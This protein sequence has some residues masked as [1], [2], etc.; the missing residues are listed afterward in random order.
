MDIK[1]FKKYT[2]NLDEY[3]AYD[4]D[5]FE[6]MTDKELEEY[7]NELEV[8]GG[9]NLSD[10]DHLRAVITFRKNVTSLKL[11]RGETFEDE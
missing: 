2:R 9:G 7:Q 11:S 4:I 1:E 10:Y 6:F 3:T 8:M 5:S